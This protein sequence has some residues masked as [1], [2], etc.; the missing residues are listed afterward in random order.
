M[1]PPAER[2]YL[3]KVLGAIG[4]ML[5]PGVIGL[6]IG[7]VVL[8]ILYQLFFS[9]GSGKTMRAAIRKAIPT[10]RVRSSPLGGVEWGKLGWSVV[11]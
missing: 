11:R 8:A 9:H 6:F 10:K 7:P 3:G 4:G 1:N 2:D 5:R